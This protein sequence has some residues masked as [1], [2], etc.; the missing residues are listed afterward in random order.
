M[1]RKRVVQVFQ[2]L[3]QNAIQNSPPGRVVSVDAMS[4]VREDGPWVVVNVSDAGPG[5]DPGD[6]SQVFEPFFS[7]RP[8][9]TGLGLAIVHRIVAEHR[10]TIR[11]A[12][13][14]QGGAAM[15]V[16]LPCTEAPLESGAHTLPGRNVVRP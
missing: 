12:N 8:G 15:T 11:A 1:D 7:R 3:L 4:E 14:P 2:N 10:G 9:G 16:R 6:F 13:R 5:F